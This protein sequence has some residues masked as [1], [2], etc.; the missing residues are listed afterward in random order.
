LYS[1]NYQLASP[2]RP[3]GFNALPRLNQALRDSQIDVT[4]RLSLEQDFAY[5]ETGN[6]GWDAQ[7]LRLS[8]EVDQLRRDYDGD[9]VVLIVD[10]SLASVGSGA[11]QQD[12]CA[13]AVGPGPSP[14]SAGAFA[15]VNW[16]ACGNEA[17]LVFAHEIG[18]L[19]GA[20]EHRDGH[21]F[22]LSGS[23]GNRTID[24]EFKTLMSASS[25]GQRLNLFSNPAVMFNNDAGPIFGEGAPLGVY[26]LQD[27]ASKISQFAPHVANYAESL[28]LPLSD[29]IE[30]S[31]S[32]GTFQERVHLS[33]N[34]VTETSSF[35]LF[36]WDTPAAC[37]GEGTPIS[38]LTTFEDITAVPGQSYFYSVRPLGGACSNV[39]EGWRALPQTT[40]VAI[41]ALS[42]S[43]AHL[44]WQPIPD[45][46]GYRIFSTPDCS[47]D[48]FSS[49]VG[50]DVELSYL[51]TGE[52]LTF[53]IKAFGLN[54]ESSEGTPCSEAVSI[55]L[56]DIGTACDADLNRDRRVDIQDLN[57]YLARWHSKS[58]SADRNNDGTVTILD[59]LDFLT[60]FYD[61]SLC[62]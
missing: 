37:E 17:S 43:S 48:Q 18:H 32:Q 51:P 1:T 29:S 31:A 27:S 38:N 40:G 47:E 56:G 25:R 14:N 8:P 33:W 10:D 41:E 50:Q 23:Q 21:E 45:A 13:S 46:Y 20:L 60:Y 35:E 52:R 2:F 16:R 5:T 6:T 19:L 7:A 62:D 36:R 26:G 54:E 24:L 61:P 49:A 22:V 30:L 58:I 9:L 3:V 11:S 15:V 28:S 39:I 53:S 55:I 57:L 44:S 34:N 12:V 4:A 42:E 59:L